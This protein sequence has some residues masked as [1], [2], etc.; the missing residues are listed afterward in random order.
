MAFNDLKLVGFLKNKMNWHQTRQH[1]LAQN[2]ANAD[3]PRFERRDLKPLTFES[4]LALR[5]LARVAATRTDSAH[6][7]A[8]LASSDGGFGSTTGIGWERTPGGNSVVLEEE[9]MQVAANQ[10][11]FQFA[12][13]LY[14]RSLGLIRSALGRNG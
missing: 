12:S 9:M 4:E 8:A 13:T 3:T 7:G 11:E 1:L 5:G 6:F 10:F 2:V 14:S